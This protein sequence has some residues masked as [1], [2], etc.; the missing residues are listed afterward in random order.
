MAVRG[1]D[2]VGTATT[3]ADGS[4][5]VAPRRQWGIYIIPQDIFTLSSKRDGYQQVII[6]FAQRAMG[7]G[8]A[9]NFGVVKMDVV[10]K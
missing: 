8:T 6:E 7:E 2:P 4:F 1:K 9:T 10:T 3:A 5:T